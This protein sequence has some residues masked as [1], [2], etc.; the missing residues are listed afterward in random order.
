RLKSRMFGMIA[1]LAVIG[2][3]I[4]FYLIYKSQQDKQALAARENA[5]RRK[6]KEELE[7]RV[8]AEQPDPGAIRVRSTPSQAGVWLKLGRTPVDTQAWSSEKL[9]ELR[10]EGVEGYQPID[11]QVVGAHWTGSMKDRKATV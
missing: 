2:G 3:A 11:T 5:A 10:L 6:E 1:T 8:A 9:H 7:I 4:G